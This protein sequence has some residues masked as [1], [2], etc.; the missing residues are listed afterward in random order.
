MVFTENACQIPDVEQ[1]EIES[2]AV[3]KLVSKDAI[4]EAFAEQEATV[5]ETTIEETPVHKATTQET[6]DQ[7]GDVQELAI[8][9]VTVQRAPVPEAELEQATSLACQTQESAVEEAADQR[10]HVVPC[11][12]EETY[13]LKNSGIQDDENFQA[14]D[15]VGSVAAP[16]VIAATDTIIAADEILQE[17]EFPSSFPCNQIN[18]E[19]SNVQEQDASMNVD[20][21]LDS[22]ASV[23]NVDTGPVVGLKSL[24]EEDLSLRR[25]ESLILEKKYLYDKVEFISAMN[26]SLK[27]SLEEKTH[28]LSALVMAKLALE[29]ELQADRH[30]NSEKIAQEEA[31]HL[32]WKSMALHLNDVLSTWQ[33]A[34]SGILPCDVYIKEQLVEQGCLLPSEDTLFE[35]DEA[36]EEVVGS[37][38]ETQS[39]FVSLLKR[40]RLIEAQL[41]NI[42]GKPVPEILQAIT[43][44]DP[45]QFSDQSVLDIE[46]Q[47]VSLS[48]ELV[49]LLNDIN[50]IQRET[51][52]LCTLLRN[53]SREH[54]GPIA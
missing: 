54:Q 28:E 40:E 47:G 16:M 23:A 32:E 19:E 51:S 50:S 17:Q 52:N 30:L 26:G 33:R 34:Y 5:E 48:K 3:K 2:E 12:E 36:L 4:V 46:V 13:H 24:L 35:G 53:D 18:N 37:L 31:A 10:D 45:S 29:D 41:Q 39:N 6:A 27:Q 20:S 22:L 7:D 43:E 42:W 15:L 11:E 49:V 25:K 1:P 8:K 44:V 9:D 14:K 38:G 21:A